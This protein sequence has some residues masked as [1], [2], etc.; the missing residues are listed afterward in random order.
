[1]RNLVFALLIMFLASSAFQNPENKASEPGENAAVLQPEKKEDG[2]LIHISGGEND[3]H[4]VLMPL[5]MASIMAEDKKV[6]IYLDIEAPNL[7][8]NSAKE[9]THRH[10]PSLKE[11]LDE[12]ISNENVE[13]MVCPTCL[14]VAGYDEAYLIDGVELADK[15]KMFNFVDGRIITLDY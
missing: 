5:K 3:A 6:L 8:I 9:V 12:L 2:V 1:M 11:Q 7:V 10:F 15:K 4:K 13:I 14:K